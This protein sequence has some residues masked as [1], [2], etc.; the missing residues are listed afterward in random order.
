MFAAVLGG[1]FVTQ[2]RLAVG[3]GRDVVPLGPNAVLRNVVKKLA[4]NNTFFPQ[5]CV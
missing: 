3:A 4:R 2:L 5:I 1:A